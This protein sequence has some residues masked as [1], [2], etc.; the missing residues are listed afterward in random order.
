MTA[1]SASKPTTGP[2]L[3]GSAPLEKTRPDA[4]AWTFASRCVCANATEGAPRRTSA[5]KAKEKKLLLAE[6]TAQNL[7]LPPRAQAYRWSERYG[8]LPYVPNARAGAR[9]G[10]RRPSGKA[11]SDLRR[12]CSWTG[13][14]SAALVQSPARGHPKARQLGANRRGVG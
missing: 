14:P 6:I 2:K 9:R 7:A 10:A 8:G 5:A 3:P 13:T 4:P 1:T 11:P 12:D